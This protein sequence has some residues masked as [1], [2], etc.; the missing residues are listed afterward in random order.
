MIIKDK[1]IGMFLGIAIGDALGMPVETMTAKEIAEQFGKVTDYLDPGSH[2]WYKGWP[3]G[4]WTDDTQL[5]L[6]IA[7]SLIAQGQINLDD[8]AHRSIKA[9]N[10]CSI[11]WGKSTKDSLKRI[12]NGKN[13]LESGNIG[14]A[15]NGIA[16]K[17]GPLAAFYNLPFTE[18]LD[19][20]IYDNKSYKV[21]TEFAIMTHDSNM[22]VLSGIAQILALSQCFR[23]EVDD[24]NDKTRFNNEFHYEISMIDTFS[25][26]IE[27]SHY[28]M[29]ECS[30]QIIPSLLS[31]KDSQ[32]QKACKVLP[33]KDIAK[34]YNGATCYV[35]NSLPYTWAMFLRNP[36][37]IETLY[38]TI[39]GG[40]DTDTNGSMCGAMLGALNGTQIFPQH[41]I[42]GLWRKDE[43]LNVAERFCQKFDITD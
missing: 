14:G 37:S 7:E 1:V 22:A 6:A 40:G 36:W 17:V 2:K 8:I 5:S 27:E 3:P 25:I 29:Y 23:F 12:E 10:E 9:M 15:G 42:D 32:I 33:I 26:Q 35:F 39:A 21:L 41:L 11:G 38:D 20:S 4:R 24:K 31:L 30:D 43:I 16:M 18:E 28:E 34:I 19:N 13:R